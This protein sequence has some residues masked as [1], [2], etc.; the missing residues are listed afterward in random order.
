MSEPRE[1]R[2][3][4]ESPETGEP[5]ESGD[6]LGRS[7][8]G[9]R[10]EPPERYEGYER[11]DQEKTQSHAGNGTVNHGPDDQAPFGPDGFG[12]EERGLSAAPTGPG[13]PDPD[14]LGLRGLLHSAVQD[15][16]PRDGALDH[17]RRAVPARRTRRRHAAVGMAAAALFVGTAVPALVHVSQSGGTD[18]H[19]SI[20]GDAA[21]ARGGSGPG[22][23]PGHGTTATRGSQDETTGQDTGGPKDENPDKG[24]GTEGG[25]AGATGPVA[26]KGAVAPACT[27]A[28]LGQATATVEAPD[29]AG[30]V[31][32][33]FR[34]ANVSTAGCTVD[35]SGTV[36]ALAQGA[37]DPTRISAVRHAAGDAAAGLPAPSQEAAGLLL[38]PGGAYE[39]KFA[40][41]PVETCPPG[42]G[43]TGAP[44]TGGPTGD[45]SPSQDPG[46][47]GGT[48]DGGAAGTGTQMLPT[49]G[50]ADGSIQVSHTPQAGA[51]T[52][53]TT[54][55]GACAGTVYWTGVLAGS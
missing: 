15:L 35:G 8:P 47:S 51:P 18:P 2:E 44:G 12:Q 50:A 48:S 39:E 11:Y 4:R 17:L 45:P 55:P 41:V 27:A 52:V 32:G 26:T 42:N 16:Q 46:A 1:F 34:V 6:F 43:S 20:A 23:D 28:Q 31:Y 3:S 30:V 7:E 29:S 25:T 33:T 14:E 54:V 21:Q 24:R 40:F 53:S 38:A 13:G 19:T 22:K 5:R 49:D 10:P 37:T 36:N 9:A